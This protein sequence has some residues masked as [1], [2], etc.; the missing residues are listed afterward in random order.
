MGRVHYTTLFRKRGRLQWIIIFFLK[1]LDYAGNIHWLSH[2]EMELRKMAQDSGRA[3]PTKPQ[4][5]VWWLTTLFISASWTEYWRHWSIF[6]SWYYWIY[7][8]W[9]QIRRIKTV[10]PAIIVLEKHTFQHQ[11][12]VLVVLPQSPLCAAILELHMK[13]DR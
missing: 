2:R 7:L 4:F 13:G 12:Q 10:N 1:R 6:L 3:T 11:H 8:R 5:L 9:Y